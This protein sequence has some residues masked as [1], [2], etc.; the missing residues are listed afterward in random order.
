VSLRIDIRPVEEAPAGC[1]ALT[2]APFTRRNGNRIDHYT[3]GMLAR[4]RQCVAG[5][6]V[7][8]GWEGDVLVGWVLIASDPYH[9]S[10]GADTVKHLS[11]FVHPKRRRCGIGT[12]LVRAAR[13][14]AGAN[15]ATYAVPADVVGKR[16]F[17]KGG[18][19][20]Q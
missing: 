17:E 9:C 16:T 2:I 5:D 11:V 18:V 7:V 19:S 6:R 4:F 14:H 3:S 10:P 20:C 15:V 13:E 12:A 8:L 1:A